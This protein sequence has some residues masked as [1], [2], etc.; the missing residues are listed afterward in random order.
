MKTLLIAFVFYFN[1]NT[2]T[3]ELLWQENVPQE[4]MEMC[5]VTG[6]RY[7]YLLESSVRIEV[8][9]FCVEQATV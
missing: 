3:V 7:K 5:K 1:A 2:K 4:S 9:Y 8:Q 6:E